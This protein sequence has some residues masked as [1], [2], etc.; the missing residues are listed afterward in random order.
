MFKKPDEDKVG[1]VILALAAGAVG[2]FLALISSAPKAEKDRREKGTTVRSGPSPGDLFSGR[3]DYVGDKF[4]KVSS[5]GLTAVVFL[6]DMADLIN[7]PSDVLHEGQSVDFVL[8]KHDLKGWVAS[9]SAAAEAKTR[10]ALS[11]LNEGDRVKGK[12]IDFK[13]HG[14]ILDSGSFQVWLP[15]VELDWTWI[16]HPSEVV[17]L[18]DEAEVE[19]IRVELPEGWLTNKRKRRA[20]AIGSLRACMPQPESPKI[21]VAFSSLPFKVW[22][23]AK[24]PQNCDP[25]VLYVLEELAAGRS[26]DDIQSTTGLPCSALDQVHRVLVDEGLVES[27]SPSAKGEHLTEAMARARELN[28]D[29]IHGL[30]ASAAYPSSQ[31][32]RVEDQREQDEYPSTWPRP[33]FN[34]L[35]EDRFVRTADEALPELPIN[36]I[37]TEDKRAILARLQEDDRLRVF[38]RRDGSLP[39]KPVYVDTPEHWLLAGL[40]VA[41]EPLGKKPF[42]PANGN[43]RCRNFLMAQCHAVARKNGTPLETLFFEPYTATVWQLKDEKRVRV[44]EQEGS[45]F[46]CLPSLGKNGTPLASGEVAKHL[47]PASWCIVRMS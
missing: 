38:L 2:L 30:F 25:V 37:V 45:S 27:W 40:W 28:A 22:G 46:P 3:V 15:I 23:I 44:W 11:G 6:H 14:A 36:H 17:A 9:I 31:F 21:S 29:P 34:R 35:E 16:D 33:P 13:D 5:G 47:L 7:H 8:I 42:R 26:R 10:E 19:I 39:W 4:V 1:K 20:Q 18:G 41:F 12:I 24:T 32:I 43:L